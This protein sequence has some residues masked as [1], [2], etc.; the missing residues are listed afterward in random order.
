ML[1]E[2][3][4]S[5]GLHYRKISSTV[6]D[7][8]SNFCKAF[9]V[10]NIELP[11]EEEK[12]NDDDEETD[13]EEKEREKKLK[14]KQEDE[15][16]ASFISPQPSEDIEIHLPNHVRCA[17]HT[18][19]LVCTTDASKALKVSSFSKINHTSMGKCSALWNK[20]GKPKSS[21][22]IAEVLNRVLRL[23]CVT[24]WNSLFDAL[25]VLVECRGKLSELMTKLGLT[26]FK[27]SEL[28]FLE[29]YLMCL[30]PIALALD[31]LQGEKNCF[32]GDLLPTLLTTNARLTAVD[33]SKLRY[34]VPLI[35]AVT[36]GFRNRF[37][38]YLSLDP[39]V[40]DAIMASVSHPFFKLRWLSLAESSSCSKRIQELFIDAIKQREHVLEL[41][42]SETSETGDDCDGENFFQFG[43]KSVDSTVSAAEVQA[44]NFLQDVNTSLCSLNQYPAVKYTFLKY[45]TTLPSSAPVER[46][47][48][49]AGI[50]HCPKRNKLSDSLFEQLVLLKGN[51]CYHKLTSS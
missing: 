3:H 13:M 27:E 26:P 11:S 25:K 45:N 31:R 23:P 1:D 40:T 16:Q 19:S 9:R 34:C 2:V 44:M 14:Q 33:E 4:V 36:S 41:D 29:E 42:A 7:N 32:Y 18:L 6:T 48:S 8:G 46:L 39:E 12:D 35:T 20:S 43:K 10:F 21:E 15:D 38:K 24:R 30:K 51:E 37:G 50:I 17:S 22:V 28:D 47:F 49:F 5:S